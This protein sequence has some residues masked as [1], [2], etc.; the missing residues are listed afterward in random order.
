MKRERARERKRERSKCKYEIKY[1]VDDDEASQ[2]E[3]GNVMIYT[4]FDTLDSGCVENLGW[5]TWQEQEKGL[6]S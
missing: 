2:E 3:N 1:D 6:N 4:T 5:Y